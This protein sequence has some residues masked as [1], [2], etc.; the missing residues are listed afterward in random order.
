[1][2]S[3]NGSVYYEGTFGNMTYPGDKFNLPVTNDTKYDIAS[4]SKVVSTTSCAMK[5]YEMGLMNLDD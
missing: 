1:M 2:I 4:L 3:A 5:L